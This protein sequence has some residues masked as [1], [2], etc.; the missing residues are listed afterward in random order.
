MLS[1]IEAYF[2]SK[3]YKS[4]TMLKMP[5]KLSVTICQLQRLEV[6]RG[7]LFGTGELLWMI[8]SENGVAEQT[9]SEF[10]AP[11]KIQDKTT[12]LDLCSS[13][14]KYTLQAQAL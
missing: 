6:W 9:W 7:Y 2:T 11:D 5:C 10:Q 8:R 13:Y 14:L 3:I 1:E 4:K 12:S